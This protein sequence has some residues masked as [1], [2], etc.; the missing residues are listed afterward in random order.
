MAKAF[1]IDVE[2]CVGCHNCQIACKDEHCGQAWMPYAQ[3]QPM[4]GQFWMKVNERERGQVPVVKV[5]YLPFLGAQDESIRAYAPELVQDRE[6]GLIVIDPNAATGRKDLAEKFEGIYWNEDLQVPQGCTGCAH[7]LDDGWKMPRCADACPTGALLFGDEDDLSDEIE[8][9]ERLSPTSKV[10]YLNLP[11]RFV[12]GGFVDLSVDEVVI[13]AKVELLDSEGAV[14]EEVE[15]DEFGDFMFG[16]VE[17][18]AYTVRITADGFDA[19]EVAA[20]V[21]EKDLC[22]GYIAAAK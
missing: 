20:D 11:K 16:R 19:V 5:S 7:L 17:A 22:L 3:A 1:V 13:G 14:V 2:K 4:T 8:R 10:Y 6:D 12:A 9:A 18:A 21:S 15:T